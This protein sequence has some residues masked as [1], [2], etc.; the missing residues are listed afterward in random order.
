MTLKFCLNWPFNL[1]YFT[2]GVSSC[3]RGV[4]GSPGH[5]GS[6]T[7]T[8]HPVN[9]GV[10]VDGGPRPHLLEGLLQLPVA[11]SPEVPHPGGLAPSA[12]RRR[13][14]SPGPVS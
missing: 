2:S 8:G 13:A 7:G 3:S 6:G 4:R 14:L 11:G 10:V 12:R 1:S 5:P 9:G